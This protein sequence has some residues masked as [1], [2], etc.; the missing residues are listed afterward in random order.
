MWRSYS[1]SP[2]LQ[3]LWVVF[4]SESTYSFNCLSLSENEFTV[5]R[6]T[7]SV[8]RERELIMSHAHVVSYNSLMFSLN[9]QSFMVPVKHTHASANRYRLNYREEPKKLNICINYCN[10]FIDI[11]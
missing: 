7:S 11:D 2:P 10:V 4:D 9:L 1:V 6:A 5:H 3:D 8:N